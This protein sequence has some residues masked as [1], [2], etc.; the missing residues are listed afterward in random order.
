MALP[1]RSSRVIVVDDVRYRWMSDLPDDMLRKQDRVVSF[2]VQRDDGPGAKLRASVRWAPVV[3]AYRDVGKVV[4]HR[5]DRVPPF[6]VAQTIR[7]AIRDG[8]SSSKA[9]PVYDAGFVEGRVD[10]SELASVDDE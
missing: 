3:V 6:V 2:I 5:F 8:W 10:W 9:G 1:R 4:S 7:L